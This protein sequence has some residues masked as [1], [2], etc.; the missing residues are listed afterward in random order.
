M[1]T[2]NKIRKGIRGKK[3]AARGKKFGNKTEKLNE[4]SFGVRLSS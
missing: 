1:V 2:Q 4:W 3:V